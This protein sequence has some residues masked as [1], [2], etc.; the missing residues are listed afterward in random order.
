MCWAASSWVL[1]SVIALETEGQRAPVCLKV[2]SLGTETFSS[3]GGQAKSA[4]GAASSSLPWLES[5]ASTAFALRCLCSSPPL[6]LGQRLCQPWLCRAKAPRPPCP[7]TAA[8]TTNTS[9]APVGNVW[10]SPHPQRA[11]KQFHS[12]GSA[13]CSVLI[14]IPQ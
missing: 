12:P 10:S 7:T 2:C 14:N 9:C 4:E 8:Y 3:P 1:G 6:P 13:V 11:G 5:G